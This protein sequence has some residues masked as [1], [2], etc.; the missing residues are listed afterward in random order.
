MY[1]KWPRTCYTNQTDLELS[2]PPL[3]LASGML[4]LKECA[5]MSAV[6]FKSFRYLRGNGSNLG[7]I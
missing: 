6:F 4:L 7:V 3:S 2:K 5:N 1:S